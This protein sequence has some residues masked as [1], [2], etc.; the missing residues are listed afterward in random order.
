[1]S[2]NTTVDDTH[3]P[4]GGCD[5]EVFVDCL[6]PLL[7]LLAR[8]QLTKSFGSK[9]SAGDYNQQ[10]CFAHQFAMYQY[11]FKILH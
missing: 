8:E 10:L 1:M 6:E 7:Q 9:H 4:A 2:K 3:L 5:P 11:Q